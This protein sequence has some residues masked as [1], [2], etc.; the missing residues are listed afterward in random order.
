MTNEKHLYDRI[1]ETSV[2]KAQ[3]FTEF[4]PTLIFSHIDSSWETP[5]DFLKSLS[6]GTEERRC[7]YVQRMGCFLR[8]QRFSSEVCEKCDYS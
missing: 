6:K 2:P 4:D 5:I 8:M 1:K 7:G 3:H